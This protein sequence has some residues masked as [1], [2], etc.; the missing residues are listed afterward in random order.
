MS[1]PRT[2]YAVSSTFGAEVIS[3]PTSTFCTLPPD[4]RRIG[5]LRLGVATS[6]SL[7]TFSA[8]RRG[9]LRSV[10]N[11]CPLRNVRSI[12]LSDKS[13]LPTKPMPSR[14]SGTKESE[15]PMF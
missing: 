3:R 5:V 15:T 10:K 12:M 6:S 13:M 8:I 11:E 9:L 4:R 1:S 7:T 2:A 14:S